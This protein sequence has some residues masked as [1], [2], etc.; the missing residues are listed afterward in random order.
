MFIGLYWFN[1]PIKKNIKCFI[2]SNDKYWEFKDDFGP[3]FLKIYWEDITGID[4][5]IYFENGLYYEWITI[6]SELR[7]NC[8]NLKYSKFSKYISIKIRS[9]DVNIFF[10]ETNLNQ[11][12][13]KNINQIDN[14]INQTLPIWLF[15]PFIFNYKLRHL[16]QKIIL[17]SNVFYFL[18][19][20]YQILYSFPS[21][22]NYIN[23]YL[24]NLFGSYY[25]IFANNWN[26]FLIRIDYLVKIAHI[27]FI[28]Q[29]FKGLSSIFNIIFSTFYQL[30]HA[31]F[32][33]TK[34]IL[35]PIFNL[36]RYVF[37]SPISTI[38]LH[39]KIFINTLTKLIINIRNI[40]PTTQDMSQTYNSSKTI[41]NNLDFLTK[42]IRLLYTIICLFTGHIYNIIK[43]IFHK[44]RLKKKPK[45]YKSNSDILIKEI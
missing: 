14:P 5:R 27:S 7:E 39:L 25:I 24:S 15:I 44:I 19:T 13:I 28:L 16:A 35:L 2:N 18:W 41:F 42:P 10:N 30:V 29:F 32:I 23:V 17:I 21:V 22:F 38:C 43:I 33:I 34:E 20:L 11:P 26:E 8:S 37:F 36:I 45:E 12:V 31:I 1:I 40:I 9:N 4:R 3:Q 6:E